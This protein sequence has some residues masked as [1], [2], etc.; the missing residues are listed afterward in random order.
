MAKELVQALTVSLLQ[1][2]SSQQAERIQLT[3]HITRELLELGELALKI[4]GILRRS[5]EKQYRFHPASQDELFEFTAQVLDFF[6]YT[7]EFLAGRVEDRDL[8]TAQSMEDALDKVCE[9]LTKRS[10]KH[11]EKFG[12]A[13]PKG[14]L[15]FIAI[16]E[17]LERI[18]DHCLAIARAVRRIKAVL[19]RSRW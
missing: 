6:R 19:S 17:Y 13:D 4:L 2:G 3:E 10:R 16:V 7:S 12:Q 14:E 9:R 1:A 8:N 15:A 11:L 5:K 18:G